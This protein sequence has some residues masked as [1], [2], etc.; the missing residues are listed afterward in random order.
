MNRPVVAYFSA[1]YAIA[2]D[3]PIY[4][5]GLGILAADIV[6]ESGS[7]NQEFYALGLVYHEAFT[8]DDPDQRQMTERLTANGFEPATDEKGERIVVRVLVE[9]RT[10]ALQGWVKKWGQTRLI[11]LDARLDENDELDRAVSDHLYAKD[12]TLELAQEICL[13]FGGVAMLEAMGVTPDVYHL[14][15]GHTALAGL[16]LVLKHL[17]AHPELNF[18]QA[19]AAASGKIVGTKHTVLSGAGLILDW[20]AVSQKLEP[21]LT[22]HRATLDDLKGVSSRAIGDYSDTKLLLTLAHRASGVS[23]MHVLKEKELHASSKLIPITNG[24]Y[25]WR[26]SSSSWDGEPLKYDDAKFWAIHCENRHRLLEHVHQ[27]TGDELNPDSLTVVWARR[28]ASYKRPE[29]LVSDLEQLG[30]LISDADRPVQFIV[31][32]KPNPTD[33]EGIELMNRVI[34]AARLPNLSKSFAYLPHYHPVDAKFLV[35]GADLWLNTPIPGYEACGTSGMK[36]SLNGSLQFSSSDGWINEV[37]L[38]PIGWELPY[39]NSADALYRMLG[40]D[41]APLF[42]RRTY[43]VPHDWIVMMRANM[44]LITDHFTVERMLGDYYEK[45]YVPESVTA[46]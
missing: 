23:Q 25:R 17:K 15:E 44:K 24:I 19:V 18:E 5:G 1:E 35:R 32:G 29:L 43:G 4:A 22:A 9:K 39:E 3:L 27:Q 30:K 10:V 14:N 46:K 7:K 33:S 41:I 26:W 11:L 21:T 12:M 13:G 8:G 6:L 2:D 38:K 45:L 16:A 40:Q 42:Y 28:M 20:H 36:A 34:E 31:A 37:K